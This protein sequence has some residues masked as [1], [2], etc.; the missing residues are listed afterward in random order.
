MP[1]MPSWISNQNDLRCFDLLVTPMLSI[2]FQ[3]NQ[4]FVSGEEAKNRFSRLQPWQPSW[5][6]HWNNLA[7]FNL[8]LTPILPTKFHVYWPFISREAKNRFSRR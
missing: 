5:I 1:W 8:Q 7:I 3:D 4:P 2:K 6:S